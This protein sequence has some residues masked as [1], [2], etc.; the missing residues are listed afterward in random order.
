MQIL[1][2]AQGSGVAAAELRRRP[3][4]EQCSTRCA[5][6]GLC[7]PDAQTQALLQVE[8]Q[9]IARR[10]HERRQAEEELREQMR[11]DEFRRQEQ[12]RAAGEAFIRSQMG[13]GG[14]P[15]KEQDETSNRLVGHP[16]GIEPTKGMRGVSQARL[17]YVRDN[18]WDD[19]SD[20]GDGQLVSFLG[21]G[22][23]CRCGGITTTK[24]AIGYGGLSTSNC[25]RTRK[26]DS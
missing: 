10:A 20:G 16:S 23:Q 14:R 1:K 25:P 3:N 6:P 19:L 2:D 7:A 9:E 13:G 12:S 22:R 26:F 17:D 8:E 5:R 4:Q 15:P 21:D 18:G 11:R 24:Y